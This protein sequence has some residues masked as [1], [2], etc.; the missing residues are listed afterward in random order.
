M[1]RP[2]APS[3]LPALAGLA[4]QLGYPSS[5]EQLGR[6]LEPLLASPEHAVW[7]AEA[8]DSGSGSTVVAWIHVGAARTL[9]SDPGGEI[10]GLVVHQSH[11]NAGLGARLVEQA[12]AWTA[13][14]GFRRLR[15]RSNVVREDAHRFY[16][17][18]GFE[19]SKTQ[20]VLDRVDIHESAG[21]STRN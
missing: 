15:V 3:D 6:R 4:G 2:A 8:P 12:I 19:A 14:R 17:R 20:A 5:V 10:Y 7:V 13:E 16:R 21:A 1:I 11:R 9:E 18:M